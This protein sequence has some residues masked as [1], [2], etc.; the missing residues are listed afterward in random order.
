MAS[1]EICQVHSTATNPLSHLPRPNRNN[2]EKHAQR[3]ILTVKERLTG[4]AGQ[5][6]FPYRLPAA[7]NF[8]SNLCYLCNL[9]FLCKRPPRF[10]LPPMPP[11]R[12]QKFVSAQR[13]RAP[14]SPISPMPPIASRAASKI[15][16]GS[17]LQRPVLLPQKQPG[18]TVCR[19]STQCLQCPVSFQPSSAL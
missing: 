1:S 14:F 16:F 17:A 4:T 11:G 3:N 13:F 12:P 19:Q 9:C 5:P 8:A 18:A 6:L 15:C 2:N 7:L 10:P